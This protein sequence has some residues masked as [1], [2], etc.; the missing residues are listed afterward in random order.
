ML[1]SQGSSRFLR[2][3]QEQ[4]KPAEQQEKPYIPPINWAEVDADHC[5]MWLRDNES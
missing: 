5:Y 2:Q 4:Q 1:E 3:N